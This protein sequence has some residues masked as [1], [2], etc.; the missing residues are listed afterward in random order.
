L[1]SLWSR[2]NLVG[3]IVN[4]VQRRYDVLGKNLA[5]G[6]NVEKERRNAKS[7]YMKSL[8]KDESFGG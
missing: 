7:L 2:F 6:Q 1:K 8:F 3:G 5:M 4:A